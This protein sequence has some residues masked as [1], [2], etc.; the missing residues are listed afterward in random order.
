MS[1]SGIS[2]P[3]QLAKVIGLSYVKAEA[4]QLGGFG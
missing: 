3:L 4:L 1:K 2:V